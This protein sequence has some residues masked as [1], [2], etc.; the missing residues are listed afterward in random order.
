[1]N[2]GDRRRSLT[3]ENADETIKKNGFE[4]R[5]L[6]RKLQELEERSVKQQKKR[7]E[8][9]LEYAL[10]NLSLD[11][12]GS[13]N[14]LTKKILKSNF[15]PPIS[16]KTM[17]GASGTGTRRQG[18]YLL[19]ER[20]RG[21]KMI[22]RYLEGRGPR[23]LTRSLSADS[24]TILRRADPPHATEQ[25]ENKPGPYSAFVKMHPHRRQVSFTEAEAG[26]PD[27]KIA[28]TLSKDKATTAR[29]VKSDG[30]GSSTSKHR[31]PNEAVRGF[32]ENEQKIQHRCLS[33]AIEYKLKMR[34][35][36]RKS[37]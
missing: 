8:E 19:A 16:R 11:D 29:R 12:M 34:E 17:E 36:A 13:F 5:R 26:R 4:D 30:A 3:S 14:G 27:E 21:S 31:N 6:R 37:N 23:K 2:Y 35:L 9:Q 20:L 25:R 1:M 24:G 10:C 33:D 22:N 15:L 7:N 18:N 28:K 32:D